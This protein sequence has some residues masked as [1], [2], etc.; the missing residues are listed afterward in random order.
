MLNAKNERKIP[1]SI[2]AGLIVWTENVP[3]MAAI[4][5]MTN[6]SRNSCLSTLN[7]VQNALEAIMV[8]F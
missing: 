1:G 7:R 4:V 8:A 6:L 2:H 3:N 5:R